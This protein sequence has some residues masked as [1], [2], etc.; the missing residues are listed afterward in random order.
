MDTYDNVNHA[1][2]IFGY[3]IFDSNY[4]KALPLT[5]DSFNLIYSPSV[6]DVLFAMFETVVCAVRYI[7][8]RGKIKSAE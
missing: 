5:L 2:S 1:L 7:N 6:G 4:K 3:C 8:N